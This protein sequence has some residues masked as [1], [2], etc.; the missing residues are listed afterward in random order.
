MATFEEKMEKARERIARL[1]VGP[2]GR[3]E[4]PTLWHWMLSGVVSKRGAFLLDAVTASALYRD[5]YTTWICG[6]LAGPEPTPTSIGIMLRK[7]GCTSWRPD[8][9]K[10]WLLP[11][12]DHDSA[13]LRGGAYWLRRAK[14]VE[15]GGDPE[16]EPDPLYKKKNHDLYHKSATRVAEMY[17]A[18]RL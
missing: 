17:R 15:H 5:A 4:R 10:L 13:R 8:R 3:D 6:M 1:S 18:P 16:W 11:G 14:N 7:V 12:R 2:E 9:C